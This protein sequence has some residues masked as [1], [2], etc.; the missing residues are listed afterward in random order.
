MAT[1][2]LRL[3]TC[4]LVFGS[5][6]RGVAEEAKPNSVPARYEIAAIRTHAFFHESGRFDERELQDPRLALWNVGIGGGDAGENISN[7]LVLV[8]VVGPS[9]VSRVRGA[10]EL[11][12]TADGY[13]EVKI[14]VPIYTLFTEKH[15]VTAPFLVYGIQCGDLH[16]SARVRIR[17]KLVAAGKGLIPFRCGE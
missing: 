2:L 9:F 12:A 3:L 6:L 4:A 16:L 15:K 10:I 1:R 11:V 5:P 13:P 7:T 17:D 8:D 14:A